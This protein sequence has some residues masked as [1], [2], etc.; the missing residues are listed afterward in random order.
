MRSKSVWR[1]MALLIA[2]VMLMT[3]GCGS[4]DVISG[5]RSIQKSMIG[6]NS[7]ISKESKWINSSI[8]GGID[9]SLK[10]S[11]K[12]DYYTAINKEWLLE[13]ELPYPEDQHPDTNAV[14]ELTDKN[15]DIVRERKL[16]IIKGDA[17][18]LADNAPTQMTQEQTD[19][20]QAQIRHFSDLYSDQKTRDQMGMEPLRKYIEAIR[21]ISSL[22]EMNAFILDGDLNYNNN[23][24]VKISVDKIDQDANMRYSVILD[25]MSVSLPIDYS[26]YDNMT[27]DARA[28]L[29]S[30][31]RIQEKMLEGLG[32]SKAEADEVIDL[33]RR[34]EL[35]I[36]NVLSKIWIGDGTRES[37]LDTLDKKNYSI[38]EIADMQGDFP[39]LKIMES[40]GVADSELY[41]IYQPKALRGLCA[42]YKESRLEEIKAY[43]IIDL[44]NQTKLLVGS[45]TRDMFFEYIAD[46]YGEDE[47]VEGDDELLLMVSNL[48]EEPLEEIYAMYYCKTDEKEAILK[49]TEMLLDAS[50]EIIKGEDWLS[51]ATKEKAIHKLDK[52]V[53]HALY[54]EKFEDYSGLDIMDCDNI[55]EA[56]SKMNNY[57]INNMSRKVNLPYDRSAWE[58]KGELATTVTNA[59]YM[60]ESNSIYIQAGICAS[61]LFYDK[62]RSL[63]ENLANGGCIIGHEIGHAF[64]SS[65]YKYD[66]YGIHNN[67]W[68]RENMDAY[69]LRVNRLIKAY[70]AL[71]NYNTG[72]ALDGKRLSGEAIGDML[73]MRS[74]LTVAAKQETFDYEK[75]FENYAKL[76]RMKGSYMYLENT[77][78]VDA[79]PASFLRVNMTLAQFEEF[80][81][82]YDLKEGDG[83][84]INPKD[85]V[86]VW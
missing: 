20:L 85:R 31:I 52:M 19:S 74:V 67:W 27:A 40:I 77:Y 49:M 2:S 24:L 53:V 41:T 45:D 36:A 37:Y 34:Y 21:N 68:E 64:D 83:M 76:W 54:P 62:N 82:T 86:V 72:S 81:R 16:A 11:C 1:G 10:T 22:D 73:G 43:Y 70:N 51:D 29:L 30:Q 47:I 71:N 48:F 17:Q 32:Y 35:R 18:S 6:V 5:L 3:T 13:T 78:E 42:T 7:P 25:P 33:S 58:M 28:D 55:I 79:H 60:P 69:E 75:L 39:L 57:N 4:S 63:E 84:Y 46:Q 65:G 61:G 14:S 44:L 9:S 56:M 12:D 26:M 59:G 80:A 50:R 23:Y 66:E 15:S 38:D 8:A